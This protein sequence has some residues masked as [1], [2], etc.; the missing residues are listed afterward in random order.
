M[1]E[2]GVPS[3]TKARSRGAARWR[4]RPIVTSETATSD[5]SS[6][7]VRE[8]T[9]ELLPAARS[10]A[11]AIYGEPGRERGVGGPDHP[12]ARPLVLLAGP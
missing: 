1:K 12:A 9:A 3:G 7:R 6:C 2:T 4:S 11:E 8:G 5:R 10:P